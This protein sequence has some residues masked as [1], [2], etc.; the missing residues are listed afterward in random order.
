MHDRLF[1][2]A[3][4]AVNLRALYDPETNTWTLR[5]SSSTSTPSGDVVVDEGETYN[6]LTAE[7]ACDVAEAVLRG[8][9]G[10]L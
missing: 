9:L 2:V 3:P 8:R 1:F 10:V 7:E 6:Y 4:D 5:A